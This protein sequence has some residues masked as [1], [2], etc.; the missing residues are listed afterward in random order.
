MKLKVGLVF[1]GS[2][3]KTDGVAQYV[4]TL[5]QW[6]QS[7]GHEVHY[8]VGETKRTDLANLHSLSRNLTVRFNQNKVQTPLP[9]SKTKIKKLLQDVSF[10][11]LHVQMPHSPFMAARVVNA[12]GPKTAIVGTFHIMPAST[13]VHVGTKVLGLWL[14]RNLRRFSSF[15]SVSTV[16][17][18]FAKQ[19]F[20]ID[21]EVIPN[22]APLQHFFGA[23]PFAKY[24]KTRNV[25][26][27]GRLVE[28]KGCQHLLAAVAKLHREGAWPSD[29]KVI[30]CGGGSLQLRLTQFVHESD[31]T[32]IVDVKGFVSEQDKPRFLAGADVAVFPS[33]GGESFGIVLIE[34]MAASR[35][36]VL[37]GNNPGYASVMQNHPESLLN[38]RD[39]DKLAE[40][41]LASLTNGAARSKARNWQQIYAKD[42]TPDVIGKKII[43]VYN[44]ALRKQTK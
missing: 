28:R 15:I 39:T 24:K 22:T 34:A 29:A 19:T 13:M 32:G 33:T 11:V 1:D 25:V 31:L 27:L 38:P 36:V 8:L 21:S 41:L 12:A 18:K 20:G 44:D 7:Q 23:K 3:V 5:G 40:L 10:D 43:A 6:L 35:G 14:T 37:A 26:F 17:Q 9:A 2:L 30:V 4:L 16:A 42:F